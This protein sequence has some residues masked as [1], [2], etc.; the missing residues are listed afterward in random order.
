MSLILLLQAGYYYSFFLDSH[1][2]LIRWRL[3]THGCIDGYSRLIIYL[4]CTSNNKASTV[5]EM[6]LDAVIKFNLPSRVRSDQGLENVGVATYM[7]EKR[8]TERRSMLT[9]SSTHNQRIERLWRDMHACVTILYYKLFYF[10]EDQDLLNPLEELHMW[11]LHYIYIPRINRS[12]TEFG[13]AWNSHPM[14]TTNHKSPQQLYTAGC[15]LLQN[16]DI[17]ALDF[18]NAVDENYGIDIG[19]THHQT[20]HL[21][22]VVVPENRIRFSDTDTRELKS[23]INPLAPSDNFGIDL[24]ESTLHFISGLNQL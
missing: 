16:S 1:H 22:A 12:L 17:E 2:K 6:F 13:A 9:G 20:D 19:G 8:G 23:T 11:A 14:R 15:L 18:D 10:M 4:R 3:V 5:Y 7:M 21:N 24:Y